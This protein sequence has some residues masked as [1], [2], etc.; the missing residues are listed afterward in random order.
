LNWRRK[1]AFPIGNGYAFALELPASADAHYAGKG[2][3]PGTP[4]RPIFWYKPEGTS[5]YHV[6][7][8]DLSVKEVDNAPQVPGARRIEN[9][10]KTLQPAA[11]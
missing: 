3:K 7:F 4:D 11:K 2:V 9:T 1:T 5:K 6:I 10:G 8:A